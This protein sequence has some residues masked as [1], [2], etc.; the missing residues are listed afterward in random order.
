M[1][2]GLSVSVDGRPLDAR[3][4]GIGRYAQGLLGALPKVALERRGELEVLR[5][6]RRPPLPRR[7]V[8]LAEQALLPLE[9]L[10]GGGRV[11]HALSPYR[12]PLVSRS[13]L[14]VTVHDVAPLQWPD[15]YLQTGFV[16]RM[17]YRAVRRAAA[18]ICPSRAA[19]DDVRTHLDV[20]AHV[21]PEAADE[22]FRPTDGS[23]LRARLGLDGP[24]LLY[25]GSLD[26]PR[27]DVESLVAAAAGRPETLVLAGA[28][29][30]PATDAVVLGAV[31]DEDLPALYSGA[32]CFVSASRYE[33]FGLTAL[34]SLAC[35]TPV[36]AMA[37][38][39]LPET[40]GPGGLLAETP[41]ELIEAAGRI[42]DEPELR[43]RLA[44][45]GRRH[46]AGY[47]WRRTAEMT[48]DVYES[49]A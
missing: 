45:E 19:R 40:V 42:C 41:A 2:S 20:D 26:D 32:T 22:R 9:V 7:A 5:H 29:R 36:A 3:V 17:L 8:E 15:E 33:G 43:E 21:I 44:A 28:G 25:V 46:A 11:H 47:S 12:A 4:H 27:K 13:N 38:G 39:A 35:G 24:Y 14:V 18:V 37:A 30:A 31:P 16:H 10:L 49:V 6:L 48:W 34:E 1:D 23:G